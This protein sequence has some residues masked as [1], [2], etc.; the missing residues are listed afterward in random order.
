MD[1]GEIVG[2]GVRGRESEKDVVRGDIGCGEDLCLFNY[3]YSKIG[4]I[5]VVFVVYVWY[6]CCFIVD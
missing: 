3:I 2:V 1:K 4:K 5:I 6:F